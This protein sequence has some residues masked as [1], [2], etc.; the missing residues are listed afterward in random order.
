MTSRTV[1]RSGWLLGLFGAI[2][3]SLVSL[4]YLATEK[5]IERSEYQA[6]LQ[7]LNS[8]V[9]AE[10]YDNDLG[11]DTRPLNANHELGLK[12][13][14]LV[15]RARKK[16]SQVAAAFP[17]IAPDGYNG[18]IHMLMAVDHQGTILGVRVISHHET[19]GLGD[20]IEA[21]R[22]DWSEQF[23]GKS[24]S[25]PDAK[26]WGVKKDGGVFDQFTGA[27]I[28]PRI[29]VRSVHKALQYVESHS[30]DFFDE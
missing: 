4:A 29:V 3:I 28:S 2:V 18:P 9:P 12:K 5:P 17:V 21:R 23:R 19:P 30:E 20:R 27:T 15:Y 11:N 14:A 6:L 25:E 10:S 1:I 24:L 26:H 7:A 22:S 16:G 8:V 13:D